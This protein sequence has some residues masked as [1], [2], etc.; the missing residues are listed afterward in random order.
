M[1][2]EVIVVSLILFHWS[3]NCQIS[4]FYPTFGTLT[5]KFILNLSVQCFVGSKLAD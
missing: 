3:I 1:A 5:I 2:G 4:K